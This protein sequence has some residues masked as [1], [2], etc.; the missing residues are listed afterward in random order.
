M[1][2]PENKNL[3]EA[4]EKAQ[5]SLEQCETYYGEANDDSCRVIYS[6]IKGM[7]AEQKNLVEQEIESHK[8]AGKWDQVDK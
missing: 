3:L 8:T 6:R 1:V 7:L 2:K 5:E 4:L